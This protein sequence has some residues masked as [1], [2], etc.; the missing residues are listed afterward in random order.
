MRS[1]AQIYGYVILT[2]FQNSDILPCI[3]IDNPISL[4]LPSHLFF[5]KLGQ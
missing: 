2:M 3:K 5:T 4:Y 1:I